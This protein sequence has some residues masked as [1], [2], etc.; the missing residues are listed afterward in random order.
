[1]RVIMVGDIVGSVGRKALKEVLPVLK[2][3][4]QPTFIV[5]NAENAAAGRGITRAI[6]TEILEYGAHAITLG[7][8]TWD[9]KDTV[10]WIG[11]E[12]KVIRPANFPEGC[13]GNG[14]VVIKNGQ[15]EL[16]V[17]NMQGRSFLPPIDCP[18][19]K[20]DQIL[21]PYK[22]KTMPILLDFHAE[23]TAEKLAMAWYLDGRVSAVIGT[24][25]HVQ[26]NDERVLPNGTAVLTDVGMTG[27]LNGILGVERSPIIQKFLTQMPTRFTVDEGIWQFHAT[28]I[29]IDPKTGLAKSIKKIRYHETDLW[30]T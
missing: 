9:Q 23:A 18:F 13:P 3:N 11:S 24:H 5:V 17:V 19:H 15:Y 1:M 21:E 26:T 12:S 27:P 14:S 2:R 30:M 25:T 7:N 28:V 6:A 10:D 4:L 22:K 29:D 16:L 20:I 8:H